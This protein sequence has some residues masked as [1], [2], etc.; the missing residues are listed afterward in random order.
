[1]IFLR[2]FNL[3]RMPERPPTGEETLEKLRSIFREVAVRIE[4]PPEEGQVSPRHERV[5]RATIFTS[6]LDVLLQDSTVIPNEMRKK[7]LAIRKQLAESVNGEN[8]DTDAY[9]VPAREIIATLSPFL[10]DPSAG[11]EGGIS[12]V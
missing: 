11:R 8:A 10:E 4:L 5:N 9:L 7:L 6:A 1:M 12:S 2:S 3:A